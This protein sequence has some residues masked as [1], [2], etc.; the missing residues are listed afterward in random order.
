MPTERIKYEDVLRDGTDKLNQA[1]DQANKS[2]VDSADAIENS[3]HAVSIA[4]IAKASADST[5]TE[6][7]AVVIRETDT[8]AMSR[9]AAVDASGV[10]QG[11]LKRR[12]DK[13]YS[14]TATRLAET[15]INVSSFGL[16]SEDENASFNNT[17]VFNTAFT[18]SGHARR[19]V[20]PPNKVFKVIGLQ[21]P[22]NTILDLNGSTLKLADGQGLYKNVVNIGGDVEAKNVSLINGVIDGNGANQ[23]MNFYQHGIYILKC[24]NVFIKDVEIKNVLGDGLRLGYTDYLS[25]NVHF[26]NLYIHDVHRN[27]IALTHCEN[28][29]AR[30]VRVD[31]MAYDSASIDLEIQD[32]TDIIRNVVFENF[33]V[34]S[35]VNVM[36]IM[37]N[38]YSGILEN[39][40][41]KNFLFT[42]TK[43]IQTEDADWLHFNNVLAKNG[44][45]IE[46]VG[47]RNVFMDGIEIHNAVSNGLYIH[48][49]AIN[50]NESTNI[51]MKNV[52]IENSGSYGLILQ[53]TNFVAMDNV[54][55]KGCVGNGIGVLS[56][57]K[58]LKMNNVLAND[59][60]GYGIEFT[61]SAD[62]LYMD[63][64][65]TN[66]NVT[67]PTIG[68]PTSAI[69]F[70]ARD[71]LHLSNGLTT[72]RFTY[73]ADNIMGLNVPFEVPTLKISAT[74]AH[75]YNT[76]PNNTL[77]KDTYDGRL[78]Y[79]G[80]DGKTQLLSDKKVSAPPTTGD[81]L[82]ERG[83]T[84]P[85]SGA[86]PGGFVGW[87]CVTGGSPATAVWKPYGKI[88]L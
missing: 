21:L 27:D 84:Y 12:L 34:D 25:R 22:S 37:R 11:N 33:I 41:L 39:V 50:N 64:I 38:G 85:N 2:E 31:S 87:V 57:N 17:A 36:K 55:V 74:Y 70:V 66:G 48:R 83:D 81:G 65:T 60:G 13:E 75:G 77:Y 3:G 14:E 46:I 56:N 8:D 29:T 52:R 69:G 1:I 40:T 16:V 20:L 7:D 6:L 49:S 9:Q 18:M 76:I 19:F 88:E 54:N 67:A 32:N 86:T 53:F 42:G 63:N 35:D 43:G 45:A 10:D 24:D 51:S 5:R 72:G 28:V 15:A 26:E 79:K 4:N 47:S 62:R 68:M 30:N 58:D 78:K 61:G 71:K 23:V 59:N 82:F 44:A 73:V 80:D